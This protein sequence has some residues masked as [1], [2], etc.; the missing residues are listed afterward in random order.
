VTHSTRQIHFG[1]DYNPE[2]W[3]EDVWPQDVALMKQA[4]VN[5][6]TLG[7]FSWSLIEPRPGE[8]DF[9][10]LD[11]VVELLSESGIKVD[12][13]TAT[14]SPPPW[15]V[16]EHPEILPVTESGTTLAS[17]SRQAYC[18]SSPIYR[19]AAARLVEAVVTRY[20]GNDTVVLW[21]INNEFGCHV[22]R[23]YCA[24][25]VRSFRRWLERRYE[26]IERVNDAWGTTFWSQ[27]YGSFDEIEAPSEAPYLRNPL[28][29]LDFDRFSS[30]E[31]LECFRNE[32]RIVRRLDPGTPVTTNFM[33]MFK[34]LNYW[35]WA[36]EVDIVSDDSYPDTVDP[37]APL[38]AA[39]SRDLMRSLGRGAPWLLMEQA[40]GAV[41]WRR[42]NA[43]RPRGQM[44]ALSYQAVARGAD[45]VLFFQW[46]QS[47]RGA[48]KFHS[49][50][51]PHSGEDTTRWRE[52]K[53]LG[54]EL[55]DLSVSTDVVGSR[56]VSNV[57]MVI[58]WDSWWAIEQSGL[59]ASLR[60]VDEM[61]AWYQELTSQ[62]CT[63][64]FV[65]P[66]DDL[67]DYGI[68]VVPT[69]FAAGEDALENLSEYAARGG[70]LVVTYCSAITDQELA[71]R[72]EGYLG[73][74]K[75][76]LGIW[77]EEFDPP[78]GPDLD[79]LR[80]AE[81]LPLIVEGD[82]IGGTATASTWAESVRVTDAEVLATFSGP[83]SGP[84]VTRRKS[85]GTAWY[86]ATSLDGEGL[87][88][89]VRGVI[90]ESTVTPHPLARPGLEVVQRGPVTFVINHRDAAV[91]VQLPPPVDNIVSIGPSEVA[92]WEAEPVPCK[93]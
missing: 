75:A 17:G 87:S 81:A 66:T 24:E 14:A 76:A 22:S 48:E 23:C 72:T 90:Q 49:A 60:Y 80:E 64:D 77:I 32:V 70:S 13:A 54:T 25:S 51:L 86:V 8:F 62:G 88:N 43:L 65:R 63:V 2:Q 29:L 56:V 93:S 78:A 1:G 57:A 9:A 15:L 34:P 28:Q 20:S 69:L 92:M 36:E 3:P 46:R 53:Q 71:I 50:M 40:A 68:V 26:T 18:P 58:D 89:L 45:G 59:P 6:V 61:F 82:T 67:D 5:L 27:R 55:A 73:P 4:G 30:D 41:N 39:M 37:R 52:V 85:G 21:H 7:V 74:L 33:G 91:S 19:A 31:L 83:R 38:W 44:R 12:M 35:D 11:K 42:S 84:A 79:A 16:A 10:W 47:T